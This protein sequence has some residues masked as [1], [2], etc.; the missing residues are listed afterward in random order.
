MLQSVIEY[1]HASRSS[2]ALTATPTKRGRAES[3]IRVKHAER[4]PLRLTATMLGI[5]QRVIRIATPIWGAGNP[6]AMS[7]TYQRA[8]KN[9]TTAHAVSTIANRLST[10][11]ARR[12]ASSSLPVS[13]ILGKRRH[14]RTHERAVEDA[15]QDRGNRRGRQKRVH[16]PARTV[17]LRADD[18]AHEAEH[19]RCEGRSHDKKRRSRKRKAANARTFGLRND[20]QVLLNARRPSATPRERSER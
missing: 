17:V 20:P 6:C 18:F 10:V 5:N 9:P 8:V 19:R 7:G 12:H 14:Q 11:L 1:Q 3:V 13:D 15:E 16:L 2:R 4:T